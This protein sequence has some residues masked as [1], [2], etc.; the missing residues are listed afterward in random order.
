MGMRILFCSDALTIDGV[1]SYILNVGTALKRAGHEVAVMGRWAGRGFQR[2]YRY[3]GLKVITCPSVSVGNI[4]FDFQAKRFQPDLI[5]SDPRRSFPLAV[6]I[7]HLTH[8]PLAT[9]FLDPLEKTDRPGRDIASLVRYSD[10]FTAF[11][12]NILSQLRALNANI[13]V[14]K[15][16]RPLDVFF[17][18]S[19]LPPKHPFSILCFGRL[20]RYKTPGIFRL[21]DNIAAVQEHIADFSINILGGGGWR[22]YKFRMLARKLNKSLG[23]ECVTITG[24]QDNPRPYIERANIVFASATS[25]ME[26]AYSFRPVIAMC[27]GYFGQVTSGNLDEAVKSYF[28]ERYAHND[29]RNLLP[30]LF[31]IYDGYDELSDDLLKVSGKLGSDFAVDEMMKGFAQIMS[32][33]QWHPKDSV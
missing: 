21:L 6:R 15:M 1:T 16:V 5:M 32:G 20:S 28:S 13:P 4:Y 22:L 19:R 11:E 25:A 30:D 8:A 29:F 23:R 31:R 12:P 18:P 9:Y 26:A 10:V 14:V 7:K 33:I 17:V 3:E 2:R 27:S 24:T